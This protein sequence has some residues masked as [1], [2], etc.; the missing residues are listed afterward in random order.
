MILTIFASLALVLAA[1]GI[2]G[3]MAYSVYQC[4]QEIGIRMA[5]GTQGNDI[6]LMVLKQ[7]LVLVAIGLAIVSSCHLWLNKI[8]AEPVIWC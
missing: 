6:V 2:Y 8:Y 3:I 7:C 5:L 1:I 4:T